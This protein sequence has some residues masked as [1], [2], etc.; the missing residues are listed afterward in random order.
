MQSSIHTGKR[1]DLERCALNMAEKYQNGQNP[2]LKNLAWVFAWRRLIKDLKICCPGFIEID[3]GIALSQAFEKSNVYKD[4][5]PPEGSPAR[6][7][8]R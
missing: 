5:E 3:Y 1:Q 6:R 2:K 8:E 4:T 7:R